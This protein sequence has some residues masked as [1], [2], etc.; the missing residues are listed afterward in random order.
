MIANLP[1]VTSGLPMSPGVFV[2]TNETMLIPMT[3]ANFHNLG[4]I[5]QGIYVSGR[6]AAGKVQAR[7]ADVYE[8]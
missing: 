5:S 6:T 8:S 4:L 1:M 2:T 7:R 3:R